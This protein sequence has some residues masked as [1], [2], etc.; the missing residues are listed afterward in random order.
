LQ[1]TLQDLDRAF[2]S[3]FKKL[4]GFPKFKKRGDSDSFKVHQR[5]VHAVDLKHLQILKHDWIRC[6]GL[7]SDKLQDFIS[8]QSLTVSLEAG[9]FYASILY[10]VPKQE[11][12][13]QHLNKSCGIDLGVSKPYTLVSNSVS[14]HF[15]GIKL[16]R[17][18]DKAEAKRKKYQRSLSRKVKG[19]KNRS[20][21][22]R[23][24]W[25]LGPVVRTPVSQI[26]NTRSTRVGAT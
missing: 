25:R 10:R 4:N 11:L 8:L 12:S 20:K 9:N 24:L 23:K 7:R 15:T 26:G 22:R 21:V 1:Q 5:C 13:H 19:S 6:K 17:D 14:Q 3:F 16:K 2:K 18:L